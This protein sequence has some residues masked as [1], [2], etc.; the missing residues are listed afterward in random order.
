MLSRCFPIGVSFNIHN[1]GC[2]IIIILQG[3]TEAKRNEIIIPKFFGLWKTK[4]RFQ[5]YLSYESACHS[6][7]F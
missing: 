3:V 6:F 5:L 2:V 7:E 1:K 4:S